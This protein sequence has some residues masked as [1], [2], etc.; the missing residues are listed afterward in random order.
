MISE[1]LYDELFTKWKRHGPPYAEWRRVGYRLKHFVET[2]VP[3]LKGRRVLEI[4][5]N[6]GIFGLE[7]SRVADYYIGVEAALKVRD[8]SKKKLPKVNFYKQ[9]EETQP[10]FKCDNEIANLT[11]CEF[12]KKEEF[13]G[14]FDTFFAAFAM[15]HFMDEELAALD[16][17]VFPHCDLV[18]IQGREQRRPTPHNSQKL[19]RSKNVAK[20]FQRLGYETEIVWGPGEKKFSE[21]IA[22]RPK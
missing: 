9:L 4:G 16:K 3:L 22:R 8:P 6:A 17:H 2:C 19:W 10:Y 20:Y 15:Y 13:R 5:A 1:D 11:I 12:C 7:I 21:I 14:E 18:V